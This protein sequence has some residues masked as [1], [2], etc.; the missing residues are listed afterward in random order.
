MEPVKKTFA[1]MEEEANRNL[2]QF[3]FLLFIPNPMTKTIKY[4]VDGEK[5]TPY[6][7][8]KDDFISIIKNVCGPEEANRLEV[9][10]MEYGVPF[11]YDRKKKILRQVPEKPTGRKMDFSQK[12]AEE[13]LKEKQNQGDDLSSVFQDMLVNAG[14]Y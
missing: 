4:Y 9:A 11:L 8:N 10:C 1:D 14:L 2:N 12:N 7:K 13:Y 6:V 5:R 3:A